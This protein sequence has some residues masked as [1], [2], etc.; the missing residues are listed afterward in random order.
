LI[1]VT[2]GRFS[3]VGLLSVAS[4]LDVFLKKVLC[5]EQVRET[6]LTLPTR[7]ILSDLTLK[8]V[9]VVSVDVIKC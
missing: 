1:S 9:K 5:L 8:I 4:D 3:T 2:G 6:V 7:H